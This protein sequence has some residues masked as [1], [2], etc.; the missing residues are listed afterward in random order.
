[1]TKTM[2]NGLLTVDQAAGAISAK[3]TLLL[4]GSEE[5][6]E[7]MPP[8]N[9]I[10]GTIPYF[11]TPEGGLCSTGHVFATEL[12]TA[13]PFKGICAYNSKTLDRIYTDASGATAAFILIPGMSDVHEAFALGAPWFPQFGMSPLVGWVAGVH[14]DDIKTRSP[15]VFSGQGHSGTEEAVVMHTGYDPRQP[16]VVEIVNLFE[17][18]EGP[19]I[20]FPSHG[21]EVRRCRVSGKEMLFA[22]YVEREKIDTRLPLVANLGGALVN[23]SFQQVSAKEGK[24]SFYAPVFAGLS[25]RI[26]RPIANYKGTFETVVAQR[27]ASTVA[28]SCNCILNY[29]YSCLEGKRLGRFFGPFTFGEIAYQLLNQTLVSLELP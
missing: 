19:V 18:G 2:T 6:L 14:L 11:M 20:T 3:K 23:V 1:M 17:P 10:G 5:V 16:P 29:L 15:R 27:P 22:E 9:W 21:F 4:A 13:M 12:P 7:K 28:F 25:Y 8:G 24:V 26:A